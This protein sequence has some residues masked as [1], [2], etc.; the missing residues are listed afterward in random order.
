MGGTRVYLAPPGK[1]SGQEFMTAIKG[2]KMSCVLKGQLEPMHVGKSFMC[3][4]SLLL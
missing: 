1:E 4:L 3:H 2:K